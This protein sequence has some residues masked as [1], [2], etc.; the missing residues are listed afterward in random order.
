MREAAEEN[1]FSGALRRAI[2]GR[3]RDLISLAEIV[4]RHLLSEFLAG[5]HPAFGCARSARLSSR[6]RLVVSA[7]E[8]GSRQHDPD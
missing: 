8:S 6:A 5:S 1:T 4:G 3:D 2:H 7:S